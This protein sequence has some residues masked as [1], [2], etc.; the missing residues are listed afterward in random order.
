[1]SQRAPDIQQPAVVSTAI[2]YVEGQSMTNIVTVLTA[3][4]AVGIAGYYYGAVIAV[5]IIL[6]VVYFLLVTNYA[7]N[8]ISSNLKIITSASKAG[9]ISETPEGQ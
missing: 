9:V 7:I 4:A 5:I 6:L 3:V 8:Q 2:N 1:M